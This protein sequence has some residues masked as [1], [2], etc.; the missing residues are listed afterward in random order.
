ML[1]P[2]PV[3]SATAVDRMWM[4]AKD[5]YDRRTNTTLAVSLGRAVL[6]RVAWKAY[7]LV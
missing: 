2:R 1:M 7:P 4:S 3:V 6:K 5:G